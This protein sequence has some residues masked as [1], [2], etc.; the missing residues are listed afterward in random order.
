MPRALAETS[1]FRT[2]KKRIKRA[3]RYDWEKM[4]QVVKELMNDRSLARKHRD[5]EL[6]GDCAGV[7][8]CHVEQD[9]LLID[10]KEGPCTRAPSDAFA[11]APTANCSD[12]PSVGAASGHDGGKRQDPGHDPEHRSWPRRP[13]WRLSRCMDERASGGAAF[14][15]GDGAAG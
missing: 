10:D 15:R 6:S 2:D 3:G 5:H 1:H 14:G 11:R 12:R 9:W 4:R 8:E 13:R 7:R